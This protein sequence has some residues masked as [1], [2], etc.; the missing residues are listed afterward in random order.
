MSAE[1]RLYIN[2]SMSEDFINNTETA[3][4]NQ[5]NDEFI[6]E[7]AITLYEIGQEDSLIYV[8]RMELDSE[9]E[10]WVAFNVSLVLKHWLSSPEENFGLQLVCR[11]SAGTFKYNEILNEL[12]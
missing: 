9:Q 6:Q 12:L 3:E 1:L 2:Q 8:D 11:S 7:F 4:K 5:D 10:G